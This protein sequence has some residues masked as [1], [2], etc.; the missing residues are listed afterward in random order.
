[1]NLCTDQLAMMLA[2]EG[3]L[4]SV[5]YLA[6]DKR[7]SAMT[8]EAENYVINHGR[9]EEIYLLQPDLVIAGAYSTRATVDMLRRLGVPVA[10]I[11]PA[12]SLEDVQNRI[13]EIGTLLGREDSAKKTAQDFLRQLEMLREPDHVGPRAA[14][15]SARG[16]TAGDATLA[17]QIL[18]AAGLQNIAAEMGFEHGGAMPLEVLAMANPDMVITSAPY[19][20]HSRSEEILL[21]PVVDTYRQNGAR[22]GMRD[23]DWVCGTPH[24]LR[25][26]ERLVADRE[27]FET[28][29]R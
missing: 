3:Q 13:V 22:A 15:Y 14:L 9:A 21:H 4:L 10:V 12:R 24:V 26:I 8:E 17:G 19:S 25:A 6:L 23:S 11:Q 29:G 1:M 7:S 27:Q 18:R 5:S 28:E 2:K 20:G 16:W